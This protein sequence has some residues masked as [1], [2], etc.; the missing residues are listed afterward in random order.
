MQWKFMFLSGE[1]S[2]LTAVRHSR[3]PRTIAG[4]RI[5]RVP[6]PSSLELVHNVGGTV[7]DYVVDLQLKAGGWGINNLYT[8]YDRDDLEHRGSW[9]RKLLS[10]LDV[11]EGWH[12]LG[13]SNPCFQDENLAS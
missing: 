3:G 2:L 4:G 5:S 8:G 13:E 6:D 1:V 12:P 7:E 9:Y 11:G 10:L